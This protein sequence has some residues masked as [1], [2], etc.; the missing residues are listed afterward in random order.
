MKNDYPIS[1]LALVKITFYHVSDNGNCIPSTPM[2]RYMHQ[3][4]VDTFIEATVRLHH[5]PG[6]NPHN[7]AETAKL[8]EI[9]VAGLQEDTVSYWWCNPD[10]KSNG[11]AQGAQLNN[12]TF[13]L[14]GL[15]DRKWAHPLLLAKEK[16]ERIAQAKAEYEDSI[17]SIEQDYM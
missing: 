14:I 13:A 11:S 12:D 5:S 2:V 10:L 17:Q 16:A 9:K 1:Q 8:W 4:Q 3:S 7:G 15:R 6:I